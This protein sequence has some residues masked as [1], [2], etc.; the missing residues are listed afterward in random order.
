MFDP[1][2]TA[3]AVEEAS[4]RLGFD[5][6]YHSQAQIDSARS[7]LDDLLDPDRGGLKRNLAPDEDRFIR[8]ERALCALDFRGY[9]LPRYAWIINWQ[10]RP[11]QFIPNVAQNIMLDIWGESER[12][13]EAIWTQNLK[14]RR[15]GISTI[16][17]LKIQH[18]FQFMPYT[19]AV[20]AS[21]DPDKTVEMAGVIKFSLDAQPWWLKP[22]P[23]KIYRSIPIEHG[24]IHSTLTIQA[25]NQFT[26]VARGSSPNTVHLS[27][28]SSWVD[29]ADL[30]DAALLPAIIDTPNTFGV[31]ESTAEGDGWWRDTWE[32]N[33]RDWAR[34]RGRIRPVFLPWYVG[35]DI[36]P[37][38]TM[39]RK[40]PVPVNWIP[41]DRTVAHAE[42]AR[43]YVLSNPLLFQY[44]AKNDRRWQMPREQMWFR[45]LGY[46]TAK[47]KKELHIFLQEYTGDDR[48]AFQTSNIPVV[49]PEIMLGY[50]ERTRDPIAVY[51]VVGPDIPP[52]MVTPRRYW[53]TSKPTITLATRGLLPRFDAK[54]QL[55]PVQFHGYDSFDEDLKLLVWEYPQDGDTYGIGTDCSEG[56][57]KDNAVIEVLREA[58]IDRAP[59]QVAEWASNRVTAFQLWPIV[60]AVS[61]WYSTFSTR[62]QKHAQ[63]KLAIE[64]QTN[65]ASLQNELKKRGWVNFH[66]WKYNDTKKPVKDSQVYREGIFVN[67]WYRSSMMDMLLTC[68]S[69]E[70]IDLPSPYLVKELQT[71]ERVIGVTKAVAAAGSHDDRVMAL[72]HPLFSLHQGKMPEKQFARRRVEYAPG[73]ESDDGVAYPIWTPPAYSFG[74]APM[75]MQVVQPRR[76]R[77]QLVRP[78]NRIMPRGFQ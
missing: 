19:N 71:L 74:S 70:A 16:T 68:L 55:V 58:R 27:E 5:L 56:I 7:L 15:L 29:A 40:N 48:E 66:A 18:A 32:Q 30:I 31:L 11:S 42:R 6:V 62:L 61:I 45:E 69:E 22:V 47:E 13:G 51:T 78:L 76:G 57:G 59:G 21:S 52:S 3:K 46:E 9:F 75:A 37:S 26:G 63:A 23:T 10:K 53:D 1:A 77:F 65:G 25:G 50:Q 14:A 60:M 35:T 49:D 38:P 24:E 34:G 33:K 12:K 28:L 44:L 4:R 2:T 8:N 39:L 72:G 67:A 20:V 54:Y 36:Y 73:L 17:E 43:Q 64:A 41:S